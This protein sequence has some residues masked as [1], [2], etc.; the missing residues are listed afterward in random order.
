MPDKC[1]TKAV[2]NIE[3]RRF[4]KVLC[5]TNAGQMA[6]KSR[7]IAGQMPDKCRTNAGQM[8]DKCRT[9]AVKTME[10]P[11]FFQ[12]FNLA[13]NAGQLPDKSRTNAGQFVRQLSGKVPGN[14]TG[15]AWPPRGAFLGRLGALPGGLRPSSREPF[16]FGG[17]MEADL[18]PPRDHFEF[19]FEAIFCTFSASFWYLVFRPVLVGILTKT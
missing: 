19:H 17:L 8:P 5:R 12:G 16:Y 18:G 13:D 6:D 2:K 1:W 14:P 3:D 15:I 10:N 9:K 7:T 4:F 11:R